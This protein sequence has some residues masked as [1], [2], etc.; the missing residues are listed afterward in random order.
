MI[1]QRH[2]YQHVEIQLPGRRQR[3]VNARILLANGIADSAVV[4]TVAS[5]QRDA[6]RA[7]LQDT[8][9]VNN[10]QFRAHLGTQRDASHIRHMS[11]LEVVKVTKYGVNMYSEYNNFGRV[12][13]VA[14]SS[15]SEKCCFIATRL[16]TS[17][18]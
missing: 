17:S 15:Y 10:S 1:D 8:P 3:P 4:A 7:T 9:E 16:S 6:R 12:S 2:C 18:C 5:I 13:L 11:V 14:A